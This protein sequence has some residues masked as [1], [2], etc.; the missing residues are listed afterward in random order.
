MFFFF[1]SKFFSAGDGEVPK[2]LQGLHCHLVAGFKRT[3]KQAWRSEAS[4][5]GVT[6]MLCGN[7]S[8]DGPK[9]EEINGLPWTW[10]VEATVLGKAG[11]DETSAEGATG[12][13]FILQVVVQTPKSIETKAFLFQTK[14]ADS[15][16]NKEH[17]SKQA[18]LLS[19]WGDG[20]QFLEVGPKRATA[21]GC[22]DRYRKVLDYRKGPATRVEDLI[23]PF[24]KCSRGAPGVYYSPEAR[25]L[26]WPTDGGLIAQRS[27]AGSVA[28]AWVT[29]AAESGRTALVPARRTRALTKME[30][31]TLA[32]YVRPSERQNTRLYS[33]TDGYVD[34]KHRLRSR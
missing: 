10:E 21:F 33:R 29:A 15:R 5:E 26:S 32:R 13:D 23:G 12:A 2:Q 11:P 24:L 30:S 22:R 20:G 16:H 1:F 3:T 8:T 25:V 9:F 31:V 28:T 6:G 17:I 27:M 14:L 18:N 19:A 4:E 34:A 7:L